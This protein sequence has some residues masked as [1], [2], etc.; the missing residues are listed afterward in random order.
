MERIRGWL[1]PS[2]TGAIHLGTA[3]T[4]LAA[5]LHARALGGSFVIRV[6]DLVD[7]LPRTPARL[8]LR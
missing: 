2:P 6:E 5:W 3:R 8:L 4:A 7:R 1:A